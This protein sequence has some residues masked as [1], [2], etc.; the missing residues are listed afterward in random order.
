MD[1][2]YVYAYLRESNNT[3]YY[4]GKGKDNRAYANHGRIKL[5]KDKNKIVF[6]ETNLT[7]IGALALERRYIRWYGRKDKDTG[8]LCNL[9]DGGDF[10]P[11]ERTEQHK[12]NIRKATLKTI[13]NGTHNLIGYNQIRLANGTH[14][15][16][17]GNATKKQYDEGKHPAHNKVTC[18]HCGRSGAYFN[19]KRYHF[20][21]CK[22]KQ[23]SA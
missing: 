12:S 19:M 8:I 1:I 16:L 21:L 10:P 7:E 22:F 18:P 20:D 15:F 5:P 2:Y 17:G 6:L 11:T 9:T 14:N 23:Q 13:E 4:I 3:P